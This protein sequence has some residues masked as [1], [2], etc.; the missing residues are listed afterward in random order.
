M[1]V[2]PYVLGPLSVGRF[3]LQDVLSVGRFVCRIFCLWDVCP[4][5]RFG[6]PIYVISFHAKSLHGKSLVASLII[7]FAM[8]QPKQ[9][10]E[11]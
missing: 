11:T 7:N 2:E 8:K 9:L 5:G 4:F 1:S 6:Y 3:V 10:C